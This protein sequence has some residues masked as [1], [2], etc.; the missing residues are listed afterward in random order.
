[1]NVIFTFI[2][3]DSIKIKQVLENIRS[4]ENKPSDFSNFD[5]QVYVES[6]GRI[7][8]IGEHTDYN[9]GFVMPTAID[10]KIYL[11]FRK[12]QTEDLC[13]IYSSTYNSG[14]E[15][16]LNAQLTKTGGW[17]DY[18]LGVIQELQVLGRL[19]K[20]FDCIIESQ[21]P[22]GAGISSSAALECGFASGLNQLF[23]LN[24]SAM[25]IVKLSQRAENNFVGSN[26]GIMDQ[27]ASV[28]SKKDH[29]SLLDCRNLEF[30]YISADFKNCK[31]LL[32]NTNVSHNLAESE[33]NNRRRD[34]EQAVE[35]IKKDHPEVNSLRD[36]DLD[37]LENYKEVL[38]PKIFQ[39]CIYVF[40]ENE[41]VLKA[42]EA[43]NSGDL[44]T[45]GE[46]MY[47]SHEG[48][49]HNYEVSCPEL[50]FLVDFSRNKKYVYGSRMMGGGFGGCTINLIEAEKIE[51]Y[52]TEAE[53]AY[54]NK[55]GISLDAIT[56]VPGEGT[57]VTK[58]NLNE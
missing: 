16:H 23:D 26:C 42:S 35:I 58:N 29:I 18:L 33:Y 37:T 5:E 38:E 56:V 48:L 14:F 10:K 41:R 7:N 19:L 9:E 22:V 55:F 24:L 2:T 13:C 11:K 47:S 32:L 6:P 50:D 3:F 36:I 45:F 40:K 4:F 27:F 1:M 20:G 8:L 17:E 30:Q 53:T 15:F 46:L 52:I 51:E 28:M 49:Q 44:K 25:E 31:L 12:N 43:L 21:L 34:C 57:V 54:H 39:R